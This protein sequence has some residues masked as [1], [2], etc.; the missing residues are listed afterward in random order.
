MRFLVLLALVCVT[1]AGCATELDAR[2]DLADGT[3][4]VVFGRALIVLTGPT[5][6]W[7]HPTI[8]FVELEQQGTQQR[9][10]VEM[11]SRDILFT[12]PLPP[13]PYALTRVEISE[14]P[15][16]AIADL[17]LTFT[18]HADRLTYVGTW[19][20]GLESPHYGRM[21][22]VSVVRDPVDRAR[23]ASQLVEEHPSLSSHLVT[24]SL[25]EPAATQV[26]LY[27]VAS[28]P[29]VQPYFRRRQW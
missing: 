16:L 2:P 21:A 6:R 23:A 29:R 10:R 22:V 20:I 15:F 18:V 5:T 24:E 8:R 26:R 28:Y 7:Y 11:E 3:L 4:P 14:G 1:A 25:P 13:G 9:F 17:S 19:R 12:I 27:E